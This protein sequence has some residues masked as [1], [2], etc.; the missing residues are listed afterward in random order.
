MKSNKSCIGYISVHVT[1]TLF[2]HQFDVTFGEAVIRG[3]LMTAI[4]MNFIRGR[5]TMDC[6]FLLQS[7]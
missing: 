5:V 3:K 1:Q 7:S 6:G 2:F 4:F